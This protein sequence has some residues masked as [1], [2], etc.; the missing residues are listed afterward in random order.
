MT[1]QQAFED[2]LRSQI[3]AYHEAALVYAAVSLGLPDRLAAAPATAEQL[4]AAL[5]LSAPHLHRFLRGLCTIGICQEL[6]DG[7]FALTPAGQSLRA[8]A[9]SRLAEKVRIVVEQYWQP[10]ANL[11]ANL[12]TGAPAFRH[13]FGMS[14]ADWRALHREHGTL[15]ETYLAGET[16]DQAG[17]IV[18]VLQ[19]AAEAASVADIGGGCGGLLAAF[20]IAYPN[21]VGALFE[22]PHVIARAKPFLQMFD[23]FGLSERVELVPGDLFAG[24]PIEADL[25]LLKGVLQQWGDPE[26]RAIL[27][28]CRDAMPAGSRLIVIERLLPE[29]ATD[30]PAA[31][32]LDLHM[33]AIAGGRARSLAELEALLAETGL[34]LTKVTATRSG[35]A[36]IEAVRR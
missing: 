17:A 19:P 20:L 25:Y 27:A 30:D 8:G 29:R 24:I 3:E 36:I 16:F 23:R 6:D 15:F 34:A 13:V 21:L 11:A 5:G 4:A 1:D 18:E 22:R 31:I 7:G 28:N 2:R 35:L 33:M 10:W 9:P 26:A 14:I 32:M 12:K